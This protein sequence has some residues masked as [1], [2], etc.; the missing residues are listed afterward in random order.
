MALV[1]WGIRSIVTGGSDGEDEALVATRT[2]EALAVVPSDTPAPIPTT[3]IEANPEEIETLI[4][5]P[6]S[7]ES[8][9]PG[10]PPPQPT[11]GSTWLRPADEMTMVY[12]P[13]GTF[14]MGSEDGGSDESPVHD[15]TLDGFWID[16][17]EVTNAQ[18]ALCIEAGICSGS[19]SGEDDHPVVNVNWHEAEAYCAWV[20]GKL[21]TEAQWEYAARGEDGRI[22]PWGDE[23]PDCEIAN[24]SGCVGDTSPVGSYPDGA[25]WVG[26][27]DM[28]GNVWEW[29]SDW[30]A[31]DYYENSPAE[32]PEGPNSSSSKVVRGG[33]WFNYAFV[34]RTS[35]RNRFQP[36]YR[37][38]NLGFRCASTP[39]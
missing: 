14:P 25:S 31:S 26:A 18:Y 13:E 29:A 28:A 15:V 6:A 37:Y 7:M 8:Q 38:F 23:T 19:V 39:F 16:Q 3:D 1:I 32:N 5:T 2:A 24:Y 17:T 35:N 12:V 33:A 22:Y 10:V 4:P 9:N 21:P 27:L 20:G 30:Y 36:E 11:L 34:V